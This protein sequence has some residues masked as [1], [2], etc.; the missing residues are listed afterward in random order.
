MTDT[1]IWITTDEGEGRPFRIQ[2]LLNNKYL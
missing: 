2:V 1:F